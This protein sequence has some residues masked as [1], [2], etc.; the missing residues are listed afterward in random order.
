MMGNRAKRGLTGAIGSLYDF[1]AVKVVE[2][3]LE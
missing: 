1:K 2:E 3:L